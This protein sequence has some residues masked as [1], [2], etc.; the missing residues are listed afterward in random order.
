LVNPASYSEADFNGKSR[1]VFDRDNGDNP[2]ADW[3]FVYVPYCTG[4]VH[5]GNAIG[6]PGIGPQEF[7]GYLNMVLFLGRIVPTFPD[8]E[9]VLLTG[10]SAGGFGSA[11]TADL[12]ARSFP[13]G[14][15]QTLIDDSGPPMGGD[16]LAP[17]LQQGW[18]ELWGFDTTFLTDCGSSCPD[19]NE[20]AIDYPLFL[21]SKYPN[22]TGGLISSTADD[23]IRFFFGF[24]NNDC[25]GGGSLD[26]ALFEAGLLDFRA[27]L[28]G[29]SNFGTY[30]IDSSTHTWIGSD[31]FYSTTAG[32]VRLVDWFADIVAGNPPAHVGP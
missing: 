9:Q 20:Y 18:R 10:V 21:T 15:K 29:V 31:R 25:A 1:G 2:V 27:Q 13:D 24:G 28:Q 4:D 11:L 14:V 26:A 30:Y 5:G 6:D 17:C 7:H 19:P 16:Y 12:V 3:N 8:V 32:G 22:S 23:T